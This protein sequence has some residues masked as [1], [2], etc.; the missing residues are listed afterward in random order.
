MISTYVPYLKISSTERVPVVKFDNNG[1]LLFILVAL[2]ATNGTSDNP[3][4]LW[5][6]PFMD[7]FRDVW[8]MVR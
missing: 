3:K 4:V 7:L 2:C 1:S 8:G 6:I 5:G